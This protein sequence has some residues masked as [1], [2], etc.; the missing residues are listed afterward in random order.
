MS[1]TRA[2]GL[3][4]CSTSEQADSGLGLAAQWAAIE[5]ACADQGLTLAERYSDEGVSGS[6]PIEKRLGL[7]EALNTLGKGDT[8]VVSRMDR[9]ARDDYLSAWISKEVE[10]K[11]ARLVSAAGEGDDITPAGKLFRQIIV[12]FASYERAIIRARIKAAA[13]A[14]RSRGEL[15]GNLRYGDMLD[16]KRVVPNPEE[17]A[18]IAYMKTLHA[19]GL[20]SRA[21]AARLNDE[22]VATRPVTRKGTTWA[23]KWHATSVLRALHRT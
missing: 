1:V 16:G 22:G 18:V 14:K 21:I 8:L 23:A 4:R 6:A 10:R 11:G 9:L 15:W 2:I 13:A 3:T 7:V 20:G 19:S 5:K 12:A 17:Q